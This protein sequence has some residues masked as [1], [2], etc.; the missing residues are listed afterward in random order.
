M[1]NYIDMLLTKLSVDVNQL[2]LLQA[3]VPPDIEPLEP[4][5]LI[6]LEHEKAIEKPPLYP[7]PTPINTQLDNEDFYSALSHI[8]PSTD[9]PSDNAALTS[10]LYR[11]KI[12]E[13]QEQIME[14]Q[15]SL[16]E[17]EMHVKQLKQNNL[18]LSSQLTEKDSLINAVKQENMQLKGE[19]TEKIIAL[20]QQK[21]TVLELQG[22]LSESAVNP[23]H[24]D[25]TRTLLHLEQII[26]EKEH[27]IQALNKSIQDFEY[28]E[29]SDLDTI[30]LHTLLREKEHALDKLHVD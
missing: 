9:T 11:N 17:T 15:G 30:H 27:E 14:Y 5:D 23:T 28:I 26:S 16:V 6:P 10:P 19:I 21:N 2:E 24:S 22:L 7:K 18:D 12:H 13:L 25:N 20:N 4:E 3:D 29:T 8:S 1:R